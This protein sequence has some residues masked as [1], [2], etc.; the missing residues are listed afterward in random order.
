MVE[1]FGRLHAN[2][3]MP[4][5]GNVSSKIFS[6]A[7]S[8]MS[9]S[10][11]ERKN[12]YKSQLIFA[13]HCDVSNPGKR[14]ITTLFDYLQIPNLKK[15]Q[16][17]ILKLTEDARE[18]SKSCSNI[19]WMPDTVKYGISNFTRIGAFFSGTAS[20]AAMLGRLNSA[21]HMYS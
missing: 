3:P 14:L 11:H 12:S 16:N 4:T 6:L 2:A 7:A 10:S 9:S 15:T 17:G 20:S 5:L 13:G 8:S 1:L 21:L 18:F 19:T